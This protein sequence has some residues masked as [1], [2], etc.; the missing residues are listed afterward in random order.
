MFIK[1]K[2]TLFKTGNALLFRLKISFTCKLWHRVVEEKLIGLHHGRTKESGELIKG[3]TTSFLKSWALS[4]LSDDVLHKIWFFCVHTS[5]S[6]Y[7]NRIGVEANGWQDT[8]V[9]QTLK[10]TTRCGPNSSVR[11]HVQLPIKSS[12]SIRSYSTVEHDQC[13]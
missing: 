1:W 6:H 11:F 13:K 8:N 4:K 10:S 12:T 5:I 9:W 3:V 2:R 7:P